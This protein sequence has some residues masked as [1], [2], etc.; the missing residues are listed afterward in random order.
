MQECGDFRA[1]AA[2]ALAPSHAAQ[3]PAQAL[4][5]LVPIV[6]VERTTLDG[7]RCALPTVVDVRL[8]MLHDPVLPS[9]CQGACSQ[10]SCHVSRFPPASSESFSI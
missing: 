10:S 7:Q 3:S 2:P 6:N 4:A 5:A 1:D 8:F 9:R